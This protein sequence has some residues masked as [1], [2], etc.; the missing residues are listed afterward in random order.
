M[1]IIQYWG[2]NSKSVVTVFKH[3]SKFPKSK[4]LPAK[5]L[6]GNLDDASYTKNRNISYNIFKISFWSIKKKKKNMVKWIKDENKKKKKLTL[7]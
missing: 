4:D 1:L 6:V 3:P 5:I 7:I 2:L